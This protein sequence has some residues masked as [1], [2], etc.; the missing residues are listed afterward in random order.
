MLL[1]NKKKG[2]ERMSEGIVQVTDAN[3]NDEVIK[4]DLPVLIDFWAEWCGPCKMVEPEVEKLS[5]EKKEVL[6]VGRLNVDE[7][8]DT[9]IKYG[10]SS[11]PTLML[12]KNGE[13]R[14]KLIGA[15]SKDRILDKISQH[16]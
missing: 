11:I 14:E 8:R 5:D 12:F 1:T 15:M 10:I 7:S 6:K 2:R 3:F 4:S 16:L 13:V 9:A